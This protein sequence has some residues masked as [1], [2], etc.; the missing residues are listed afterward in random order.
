M[1]ERSSDDDFVVDTSARN[2]AKE[3]FP[4][5]WIQ[6]VTHRL[7]EQI[8]QKVLVHYVASNNNVVG[9]GG[10]G[11]VD[12]DGS[13]PQEKDAVWIVDWDWWR[14]L[15][16]RFWERRSRATGSL[17]EAVTKEASRKEEARMDKIPLPAPSSKTDLFFRRGDED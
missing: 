2:V 9:L 15:R 8:G 1:A 5:H 14:S 16:I 7:E 13:V 6:Q 12:F 17:S 3:K 10:E 4:S 11:G